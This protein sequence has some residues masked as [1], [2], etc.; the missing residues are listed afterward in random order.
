MNDERVRLRDRDLIER[1]VERVIIKPEAL[2]VCLI[3]PCEASDQ[4]ED[5]IVDEQA[6]CRPQMTT[7][8]LAWAAPN[9]SAVKGI[10]HAPSAKPAMRPER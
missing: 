3:P 10:I 4:A 1:H 7:I 2:E 6:S 8:R 9:F 5:P